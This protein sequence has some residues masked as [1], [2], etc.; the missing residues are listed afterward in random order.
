MDISAPTTV[1]LQHLPLALIQI[2]IVYI[3]L[4]SAFQ[5]FLFKNELACHIRLK[6][7]PNEK[8]N[9]VLEVL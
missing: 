4:L 2:C 5:L 6:I 8:A 9:K 1:S 7:L 3:T